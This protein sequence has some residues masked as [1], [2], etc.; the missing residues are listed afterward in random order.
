M[1]YAYDTAIEWLD[2]SGIN[3]FIEVV[4]LEA[5]ALI[6]VF[7]TLGLYVFLKKKSIHEPTIHDK[8]AKFKQDKRLIEQKELTTRKW[9]GIACSLTAAVG[10]IHFGYRIGWIAFA[11][12]VCIS[13]LFWLFSTSVRRKWT[14]YNN[15]V[16]AA[17]IICFIA[18]EVSVFTGSYSAQNADKGNV[19]IQEERDR[20]TR[21]I[22]SMSS[23]KTPIVPG[24]TRR[25]LANAQYSNRVINGQ[26]EDIEESLPTLP[27][28]GENEFFESLALAL[29][30]SVELAKLYFFFGLSSLF[31]VGTALNNTRYNSYYSV[32]LLRK[33]I[34]TMQRE[35]ALI[36]SAGTVSDEA[37]SDEV[38]RSAGSSAMAN[39]DNFDKNVEKIAAYVRELPVDK[40]VTEK[41]ILSNCSATTKPQAKLIRQQVVSMGLLRKT[42]NG[43]ASQYVRTNGGSPSV[44][45]VNFLKRAFS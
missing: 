33:Y 41:Q 4:G 17:I 43:S 45:K 14:W 26:I 24:M 29:G 3:D 40:P 36:K 18:F 35:I 42:G 30:V 10:C 32:E 44:V 13:M 34:I 31:M 5:I 38:S 21:Q 16:D 12:S 20:K 37:A 7:A 9:V 2:N 39:D 23:E 28:R 25:G 6:S 1:Y 11:G 8:I 22:E 15:L 19:S 27:Q